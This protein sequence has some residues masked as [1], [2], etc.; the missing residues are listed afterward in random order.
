MNLCLYIQSVMLIGVGI[1]EMDC[2][3][4]FQTDHSL[5][6]HVDFLRIWLGVRWAWGTE[7]AF[8]YLHS[9]IQD[10]YSCEVVIML[11]PHFNLFYTNIIIVIPIIP[12]LGGYVPNS[13][14]L[15]IFLLSFNCRITT[16]FD[17]LVPLIV[18]PCIYFM[19]EFC[20][21]TL[22]ATCYHIIGV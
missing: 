20:L 16:P 10:C 11:S 14:F 1:M 12:F 22:L 18:S 15:Q 5:L 8:L 17:G 3:I 7:L 19:I 4:I 13:E 21:L 9:I 6:V 2:T